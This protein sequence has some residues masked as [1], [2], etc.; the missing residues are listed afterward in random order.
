MVH[1]AG[2]RQ[3][4]ILKLLLSAANGM[5][6]DEMAG[7]LDISRNAVKQHLTGLEKDRLIEEAALNSTGGRPSR[8]YKLTE[9]GVNRLPK[10]Y[11]WFC[12]LLLAELKTEF[13]EPMLRQLLWRMGVNLATSLAPQFSGKNSEQKTAALVELMQSLGYHAE[14]ETETSPPTIKAV[15]CVYHDLAQQHPELCDFDRALITTLLDQ[16]IEQ[17]ACMAQKDCAC[18]FK[19]GTSST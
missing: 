6:I 10:Q 11:S 17:T 1:H 2:S 13:G 18:K 12:Q 9:Q 3:E 8:N 16:P 7:A 4:Q 5:S 19:V 15:N 14:L